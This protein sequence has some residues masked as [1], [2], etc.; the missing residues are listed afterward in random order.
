M[1]WHGLYDFR[2]CGR[3]IRFLCGLP[4]RPARRGGRTDIRADANGIQHGYGCR[5]LRIGNLLGRVVDQREID[6]AA[7]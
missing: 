7:T 2:A 5:D 3:W 4:L 6:S 1:D